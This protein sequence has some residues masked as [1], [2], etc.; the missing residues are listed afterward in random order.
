M[1]SLWWNTDIIPGHCHVDLKFYFIAAHWLFS[2]AFFCVT[3]IAVHQV[4]GNYIM[5][6]PHMVYRAF[7]VAEMSEDR[8]HSAELDNW[9]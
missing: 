4:P 6:N 2:I 3:S 8:V 5:Q 1:H 9:R 7:A